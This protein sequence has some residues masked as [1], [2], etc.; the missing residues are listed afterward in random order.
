[1]SDEEH[2]LKTY[3]VLKGSIWSRQHQAYFGP[4]DQVTYDLD[5]ACPPALSTLTTLEENGVLQ[6]VIE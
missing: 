3:V 4:G 6:E 2:V 1:M 5:G